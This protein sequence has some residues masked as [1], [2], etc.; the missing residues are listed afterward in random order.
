MK[1][2]LYFAVFLSVTAMLVTAIA[3]LGYSLTEPIIAQ[4]RID[5][6]EKNIAI[7][8]DPE[9]GYSRNVDQLENSYL[10]KNYKSI[11]EIYEVL[12][13]DGEIY[14]LIYNITAQGR[15]GMIDALI[16]VDPY[17]DTVVAVTY[18]SHT[19]TPNIGEKYTKDE[20]IIKLLGQSLDNV[21]VDVITGASTTW[22]AI[23]TMF[24]DIKT[25]YNAEE[26]H[27]DG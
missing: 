8:F 7:L 9:D 14:V 22:I 12:G 26:V 16:A 5:S 6:I 24:E 25:H 18:Y 20:E 11:Y 13:N 2:T 23:V 10:E 17:T 19:E 21:E 1:K 15:N 27:I 4:N 3:Y